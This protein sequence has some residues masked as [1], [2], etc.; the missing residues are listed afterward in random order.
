M[1]LDAHE[2]SPAL[3]DALAHHAAARG[4]S[5]IHPVV[6]GRG[7]NLVL[8]LAPHDVVARV[9]TGTA[10]LRDACVHAGRELAV[11]THLA[12]SGAPVAA[13]C[14]DQHAPLQLAGAWVTFWNRLD[15]LDRMP[16]PVAAGTALAACHDALRTLKLP[17]PVHGHAWQPLAETLA[18]LD[19]PTVIAA[20]SAEDR[21]LVRA[22]T[23]ALA[24]GLRA[25]SAPL[26]WLHGDAHLNNVLDTP[27]GPAWIDW[28]DAVLAPIEWDLACLVAG[29]RVVGGNEAW[30]EAAL[31]ACVATQPR[32]IDPALLDLCI[33][34]RTLFV[35]AWMWLLG[36]TSPARRHRMDRRLAWLRHRSVGC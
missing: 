33:H 3:L 35:V 14:A 1:A 7:S 10:R 25:H 27:H 13:P 19:H 30:S 5:D 2:P 8:H 24:P 17:G 36:L 28:E 31:T 32:A 4:W 22:Q 15:V 20:A 6:I 12:A 26:Q 23:K 29:A 9:A 34:A 18:L 16:D 21:E 11:A